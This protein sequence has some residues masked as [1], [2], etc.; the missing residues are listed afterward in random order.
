MDLRMPDGTYTCSTERNVVPDRETAA[1]AQVSVW[2]VR[3]NG[4]P[5][6]RLSDKV[7]IKISGVGKSEMLQEKS[8]NTVVLS[9]NM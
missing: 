6:G 2:S 3:L 8:V 4:K 1:P 9:A 5:C 7:I